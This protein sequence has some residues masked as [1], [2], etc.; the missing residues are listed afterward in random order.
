[1][2]DVTQDIATVPNASPSL[3][4]VERMLPLST[5]TPGA[6]TLKIILTDKLKN[7]TVNQTAKFTVRS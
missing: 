7:Q 6:Y 1:V 2:V 3:V 5:F 4:T